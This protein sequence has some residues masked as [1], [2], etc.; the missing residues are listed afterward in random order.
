MPQPLEGVRESIGARHAGAQK[1]LHQNA[2]GTSRFLLGFSRTFPRALSF[3]RR[4][5]LSDS[6]RRARRGA[7]A[8]SPGAQDR[9]GRLPCN[10]NRR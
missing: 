2:N 1:S 3:T 5:D 4:P 10:A 6:D 9:Q 8:T 7:E